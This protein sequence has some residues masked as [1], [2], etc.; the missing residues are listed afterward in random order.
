MFFVQI[1]KNIFLVTFIL[2]FRN[3]K[4]PELENWKLE[5]PGTWELG[6]LFKGIPASS[7][8]RIVGD[9][10][11]SIS[12]GDFVLMCNMPFILVFEI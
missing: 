3:L 2:E 6:N 9:I 11:G 7:A 8:L 10:Q 12:H 5:V 4:F 1:W